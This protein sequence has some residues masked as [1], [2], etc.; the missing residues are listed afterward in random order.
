[1]LRFLLCTFLALT[2][3]P[4]A[5]AAEITNFRDA[6]AELSGRGG[7]TVACVEV[8]KQKQADTPDTLSSTKLR[9]G[10]AKGDMDAVINVMVAQ[11]RDRD[12]DEPLNKKA[13]ARLKS[14]LTTAKALC[15]EAQD[16]LAAA[17][18]DKPKGIWV[19][20][21]RGVLYLAEAINLSAAIVTVLQATDSNLS[22]AEVESRIR[23][24][25]EQRWPPFDQIPFPE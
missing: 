11:A 7:E 17:D 12:S 5:Q 13:D 15:D 24:L 20:V 10:A 8:L 6:L 19:L 2:V 14:A 21:G 18:K 25:E 4:I 23:S 16:F 9:Y 3:A 22:D 1:M